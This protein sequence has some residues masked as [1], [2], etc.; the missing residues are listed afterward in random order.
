[1]TVSPQG[2]AYEIVS[3]GDS[4][5]DAGGLVPHEVRFWDTA[6]RQR[7]GDGK[8]EIDGRRSDL[9]NSFKMQIRANH[10]RVVTLPGDDQFPD[11]YTRHVSGLAIPNEVIANDAAELVKFLRRNRLPL[12]GYAPFRFPNYEGVEELLDGMWQREL[13]T[14]SLLSQAEANIERYIDVAKRGAWEGDKRGTTLNL[15]V[16]ASTDDA[17]E[18]VGDGSMALDG[19]VERFGDFFLTRHVGLRFTGVSGLSGDTVD[20]A[21]LTF[22]P[23]NTDAPNFVAD[24]F[25]DDLEAPGT[26]T[27]TTSDIS[28]RTTT[29]TTQEGDGTDF[30][31]WTDNVEETF[32]GDGDGIQGIVQEL[33]DSH[34][35][36]T[37]VLLHLYTSGNGQRVCDSYD[38]ATEDAPK[39]DITHTTPSTDPEPSLI[40]GKLTTNSL[41]LRHL[42]H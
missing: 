41:L 18:S 23:S 15:Q 32:E 31:N 36:S 19:I 21:V 17:E 35:P 26:F 25:A 38:G 39:L 29:T 3:G 42:V 27:T 34:D 37:I 4:E 7:D 6:Q 9:M 28:D 2:V 24:W 30:T 40:D 22:L 1:M 20:S 14:V 12:D 10:Q 33:A 16:G 8:Y 13:H 11:G 5:R